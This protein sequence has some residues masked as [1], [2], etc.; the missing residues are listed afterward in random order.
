VRPLGYPHLSYSRLRRNIPLWRDG[1]ALR[2]LCSQYSLR[3]NGRDLCPP[4]FGRSP[5]LLWRSRRVVVLDAS[6]TQR[7]PCD[8]KL[9]RRR[10]KPPALPLPLLGAPGLEERARVNRMQIPHVCVAGALVTH[11]DQSLVMSLWSHA[12]ALMV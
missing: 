10:M 9:A 11:A 7:P 3:W 2:S 8:C 1:A 6:A 5:L 12:L 4:H